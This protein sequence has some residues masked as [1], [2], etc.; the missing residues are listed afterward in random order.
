MLIGPPDGTTRYW[1]Y[2]DLH[3][4]HL[5]GDWDGVHL[6]GG[7][8]GWL[9]GYSALDVSRGDKRDRSVRSMII[10]G[11]LICADCADA[12]QETHNPRP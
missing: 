9:D 1:W 3:K 12:W 2:P 11:R 8:V 6:C 10:E 5:G 7:R 4:A